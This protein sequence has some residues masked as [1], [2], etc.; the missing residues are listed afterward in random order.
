MQA[1]INQLEKPADKTQIA[2]P[3]SQPVVGVSR[4]H[5]IDVSSIIGEQAA[6]EY[7]LRHSYLSDKLRLSGVDCEEASY[8]REQKD[9]EGVLEMGL[10]SSRKVFTGFGLGNI[11][12]IITVLWDTQNLSVLVK[13]KLKGED[14]DAAE[15]NCV[16]YG[17][18]SITDL[19]NA[20]FHGNAAADLIPLIDKVSLIAS[21]QERDEVIASFFFDK[22]FAAAKGNVF[23]TKYLQKIY[24]AEQLKK[25]LITS[26]PKDLIPQYP[27]YS[28]L[29][30]TASA[31]PTDREQYAAVESLL[32]ESMVRFLKDSSM[33]VIDGIEPIIA[34]FWRKER[35]ARVIRSV[36]LAKRADM[37]PEEIR[38]EFSSFVF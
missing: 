31:K 35:N 11:Q 13:S 38:E 7:N 16:P 20:V 15:H 5:D 23:L 34:F 30:E 17:Y 10:F 25:G 14:E 12:R 2:N 3:S 6:F 29:L 33:V 18:Y 1:Q 4:R 28:E 19:K 9:F 22:A 26:T 36:L 27:Q 37:S 32:D 8:F 21:T 24:S